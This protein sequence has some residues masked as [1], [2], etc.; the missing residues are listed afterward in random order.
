[1]KAV[2][3]NGAYD[4]AV[5]ERP[6][7]RLLHDEDMIVQVLYAGVCGSDLHAYRGVEKVSST[8]FICGHEFVGVVSEL[9]SAV[10]AGRFPIGSKVVVPF[11]TSCGRCFFCIRGKSAR[12]SDGLLFGSPKL[13]GGQAEYVRVPLANGTCVSLDSFEGEQKLG[14]LKILLFLGDIWTTA[15]YCAKNALK[16]ALE[17]FATHDL[18]SEKLTIAVLGLGPVGL[19]T[20]IALEYLL[21]KHKLYNQSRVYAIDSVQDRLD[22]VKEIGAFPLKLDPA[23][24][25]EVISLLNLENE[26]GVDAV[27][28]VVG[29]ESALR[30]GFDIL[31]PFG[32]LSSVG[33]HNAPL[34][35]TGEACF[36][37][38]LVFYAGRCPVRS[39]MDEAIPALIEMQ[40]RFAGFV[41]CVI[42]IEDAVEAYEKFNLRRVQK[43][44]I[45][46]TCE[47]KHTYD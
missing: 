47:R 33:V 8:G 3:F 13:D 9:G 40:N 43:V 24:P 10:D 42:N 23:D 27:C 28:E 31:R 38:N 18:A 34:P 32:T 4:L 39:L 17:S 25:Q 7:P 37:K 11:T 5:V 12:C 15:L 19:C 41:D 26:R 44:V 45:D 14:D 1:M 36:S 35:F 2:V 29:H 6:A 22:H 30:L 21:K 46:F 16:D 20:L